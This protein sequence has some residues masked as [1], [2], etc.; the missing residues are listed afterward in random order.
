MHVNLSNC[1]IDKLNMKSWILH[2][3]IILLAVLSLTWECLSLILCIP[4][5]GVSNM[6]F[7]FFCIGMTLRQAHVA[8]LLQTEPPKIQLKRVLNRWPRFWSPLAVL[9]FLRHYNRL[10][11]KLLRL[12]LRL[13]QQVLRCCAILNSDAMIPETQP[14]LVFLILVIAIHISPQG[15]LSEFRNISSKLTPCIGNYSQVER[16]VIYW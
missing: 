8:C 15:M 12:F 11:C 1:R 16:K 2:L 3:L 6:Q 13:K 14:F 7:I 4:Y 5:K 9:N 10:K